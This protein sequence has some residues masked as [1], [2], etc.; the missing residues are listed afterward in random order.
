MLRTRMADTRRL[1]TDDTRKES[2]RQWDGHCIR[3]ALPFHPY[4]TRQWIAECGG[5][6]ELHS[7]A[8]T[9]YGVIRKVADNR[10]RPVA[11]NV[12]ARS[13]GAAHVAKQVGVLAATP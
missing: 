10:R 12:H 5:H 11:I 2:I 8:R 6:E 13:G 1:I 9:H 7:F 4:F 3:L